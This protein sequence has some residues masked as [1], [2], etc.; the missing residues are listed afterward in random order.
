MKVLPGLQK[1][2]L[3]PKAIA[4]CEKANNEQPN[5]HPNPAAFLINARQ[6]ICAQIG[7]FSDKPQLFCKNLVKPVRG[8]P[9]IVLELKLLAH[10]I[11]LVEWITQPDTRAQQ[12]D[13][14]T[15]FNKQDRCKY[16]HTC[17]VC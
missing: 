14:R 5:P 3:K 17:Q 1:V 13:L 12:S 11:K 2:T 4:V 6:Q 15:H 16:K 9:R 8:E 7:D 10:L